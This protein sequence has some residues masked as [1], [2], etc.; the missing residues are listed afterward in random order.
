MGQLRAVIY[1]RVST[2]EQN[3]DRQV[4]NLEMS[5]LLGSARS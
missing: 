1:A 4:G 3:C 2:V 5:L